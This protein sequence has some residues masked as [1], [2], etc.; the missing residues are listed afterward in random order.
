MELP[1]DQLVR[2]D[3]KE[4]HLLLLIN[5][6][7][8][9]ELAQ[10]GKHTQWKLNENGLESG[11]IERFLVGRPLIDANQVPRFHF[12]NDKIHTTR[13]SELIRQETNEPSNFDVNLWLNFFNPDV[14]NLLSIAETTRDFLLITG[15]PAGYS[16]FTRM[17]D[18][19]LNP[20]VA[21]RAL[22]QM[23]LQH[24]DDLIDCLQLM[25]SRR[26]VVNKQD[27]F[28]VPQ[29]YRVPID[30]QLLSEALPRLLKSF[31]PD[32]VL[33]KLHRFI[34]H[35]LSASG[36]QTGGDPPAGV[37]SDYIGA[38]LEADDDKVA[39]DFARA[40]HEQLLIKHAVNL[41][42]QLVTKYQQH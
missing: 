2:F 33:A 10:I 39:A 4:L 15:G 34:V 36:S 14:C 42:V 9:L 17:K 19:R 11:V 41:F 38:Q 35:R 28:N 22:K 40:I 32:V 31:H 1:L 3:K 29:E 6:E 20:K 5:S 18:L 37:L 25:R 12:Q 8:S 27:P 16:L 26:M 7:Y 13:L 21:V 24:L 30:E 23:K